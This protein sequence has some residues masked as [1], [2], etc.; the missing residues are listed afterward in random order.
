MLVGVVVEIGAIGECSLVVIVGSVVIVIGCACD[1]VGV[2]VFTVM[3]S[4]VICDR[5]VGC[6]TRHV[7]RAEC[8]FG[9][10]GAICDWWVFLLC[11]ML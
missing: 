4:F 1:M 8:T 10:T 6:C 3:I 11:R 9:E 5:V 7:S 2:I